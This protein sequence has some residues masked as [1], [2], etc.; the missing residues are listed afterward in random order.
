MFVCALSERGSV[1]RAHGPPP[2]HH[3]RAVRRARRRDL[4]ARDPRAG[5]PGRR[6]AD[7]RGLPRPVDGARGTLRGNDHRALQPAS[8]RAA[9]ARRRRGRAARRP[10]ARRPARGRGDGRG[11]RDEPDPEV[12]A[13]L[14][15][16]AAGLPRPLVVAERARDGRDDLRVRAGHDRAGA[17]AAARQRVRRAADR[18]HRLLAAAARVALP[19]RRARRPARRHR[20]GQPG[21]RLRAPVLAAAVFSGAVVLTI[22]LAPGRAASYAADHTTFVA[23]ALALAATA[24]VLSGSVPAPTAARSRPRQGSPSARG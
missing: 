19:E 9:R 23:G 20:L 13:G 17:L 6:P 3:R 14:S 8:V 10:S 24:L 21:V 18:R 4:L 12:A 1:G 15:A 5:D 16:P 7:A 2:A 22:A 11:E